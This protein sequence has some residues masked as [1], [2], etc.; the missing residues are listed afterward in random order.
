MKFVTLALATAIVVSSIPCS[1]ETGRYGGYVGKT[2]EATGFFRVA[3]LNGRWFFVTPDGHPYVALGAN[4]VGKYLD[5]QAEP[6]G[7]H[8]RVNGGRAEAAMFLADAMVDMGLNAGEAYAPIAPELKRKLPWVHN[9]RFPFK[10]KFAFDVFAPGFEEKLTRSIQKQC[11]DIVN[12]P[13]VIGVAFN[14][15]P[16]WDK[17]RVNYYESLPEQAP[18]AKAF[19]EFRDAGRSD[20]EFLGHVA[21]TLYACMLRATRSAAPH[22]LFLGER[23][24]LRSAP[25]EVLR[26]V[27]RHVDVFCTQAL[28]LSPQRPPEWQ[29]IQ[30]DGYDHEYEVVGKPMVVV[31]WAAPFSLGE[32]FET[33]RGTIK[34][35]RDAAVEAADW[36]KQAVATP[37]II[38]VFK[39]QLIGTH[40][41]DRWFD[42]RAR[43]T[44]LQDDGS[45]FRSRTAITRDAHLEALRA[46]YSS[47]E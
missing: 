38:G 11:A 28:I 7:L 36:L 12:D 29:L 40:G 15:L 6:M 25:D 34:P 30:R 10:S 4:H 17:R 41:N 27:G 19:R 13:M 32:L 42:G 3:Q 20:D 23:F 45:D 35:E 22:H 8:T 1:A 5:Q 33:E 16:V 2:L 44:Y 39:C 46:A 47:F 18:G 37:F 9:V 21:E 24:Y 43:R 14:D 26:A 31:D